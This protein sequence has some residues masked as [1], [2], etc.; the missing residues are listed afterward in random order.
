MRIFISHS[1]AKDDPDGR[2]RLTDVEAALKG[3][4]A[5]SGHDVLLDIK[6]LEGG[7]DWRAE[8]DEW[9]AICHAAVLLLTPKALESPWVL[10]EAT[11]LAH[12][13]ALD[14]QFL[15]FPALL[16]GLT[17][18][19]LKASR[20]SPL[21]LDAIQRIAGTQPADIANAV[22]GQLAKF[23]KPPETR[24]DLLVNALAAQLKTAAEDDGLEA[25]CE[26]ITG[27][28]HQW[29]SSKTR[30]RG[31]AQIVALAIVSGQLGGYASL[32]E[33]MRDL[34]SAGL[35]KEAAGRVLNLAGP[36][37]VNPEAA[38]HLAEVAA[39]NAARRLDEQGRAI[40]W[41]TA[42]NGAYL[43]TFTVPHYV[44]RAYLPDAARFINLDGGESDLRLEELVARLRTEVRTSPY[45]RG[46]TDAKVDDIL[47]KVDTP[48]FV[49][50]PPP[51]PDAELLEMLQA[52]YPKL[53]FIGQE[54][55][56]DIAG[57]NFTGRVVP[58]VPPLETSQEGAAL[59]EID[60]VRQ[61]I[62]DF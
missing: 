41:S 61:Q 49:L 37:W 40:S 51:F 46:A 14:K 29:E 47:A 28:P 3:L 2:R 57:R 38:A 11:I 25:I 33:V 15:L 5:P 54:R 43:P 34:L 52:R 56:E 18:D 21:Y 45:L 58:L 19:Q 48:Y 27:K 44:R 9:M 31:A 42:I 13:A 20:F 24:L 23:G 10:K 8:L 26:K 55:A 60:E 6:R 7:F 39:R 50:L 35:V 62:D 36:R 12:R 32:R 59:L 4:Q 30:A 22:L 17:R 16:D 53:T 1:T